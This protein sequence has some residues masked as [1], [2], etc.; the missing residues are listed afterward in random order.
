MVNTLPYNIQEKWT[1]AAN[2]Y[3]QTNNVAYPPF[4]YFVTFLQNMAKVRNDPGFMYE[5]QESKHVAQKQIKPKPRENQIVSSLQTGVA[6]R[7]SDSSKDNEKTPE[8]VCPHHG[9]NHKLNSSRV[10]RAKPIS[11]RLEF[12]KEKGFCFK[13]CRPKNHF[14]DK[15]HEKVECNVS[16]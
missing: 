6:Q 7:S 9:T 15:Y 2:S 12:F 3:K 16:K 10:F 11:E 5:N 4:S 14:R 13:C 1:T 8:D